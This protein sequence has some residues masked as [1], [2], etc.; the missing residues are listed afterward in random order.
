MP[1]LAC[2]GLA[3]LPVLQGLYCGARMFVKTRDRLLLWRGRG[4]HAA[5]AQTPFEVVEV[6]SADLALCVGGYL[7]PTIYASSDVMT[8]LRSEERR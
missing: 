6:R 3:L 5:C 2:A 8:S 4:R 7:K 1:L